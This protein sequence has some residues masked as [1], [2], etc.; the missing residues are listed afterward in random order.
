MKCR[1]RVIQRIISAGILLG[2]SLADSRAVQ[3]E[4]LQ[5]QRFE[6]PATSLAGFCSSNA[7]AARLRNAQANGLKFLDRPS[8]GSGLARCGGDEFV[9]ISDRGPNGIG[10]ANGQERR[11]FPLPEFS[12]F[13]VRFELVDGAI[14]IRQPLFLTDARGRRL[15]GLSN[16]AG[17]ERLYESAAATAPL[18]FDPNGVDPEA[19]RV[20]PDGKFL[21]AEEY[22]PSVLLVAPNG[23]VLVRYTPQTKMLAGAAYPVKPILP[24]VLA[25]RRD[26]RGFEAL[27]LS[28]DGRTAFA[29]LQSPAG[30]LTD[31]Q[32]QK[33][34]VARTI[35]LDLSDPFNARVTGHFLMPLSW[36]T[37]Y[38]PEQKQANVKLN[39]AEWLAP[40]KLL[41]LETGK[42]AA[43]LI[44]ADF[45]QATNLLG[46]EDENT[47]A[48]EAVGEDLPQLPVKPATTEV[49]LALANRNG[50]SQ[51]LEGLAILSADEIALANDNDF[52]LGD[53]ETGER[54]SVWRL[55]LPRPLP[56][57]G[58]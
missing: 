54:S 53:N 28:P 50:L 45:S 29:I 1:P 46:R 17:E 31:E 2:I 23:E 16:E 32:S 3:A 18:P 33:S 30:K 51:K 15:T 58:R 55:R 26:N 13:V 19:I 8:L 56:L 12:P 41:V 7:T 35:R 47:L 27:A 38:G 4:A 49:W 57:S 14:R 9:G 36:A 43:R 37:N 39:D 25:R 10:F 40:D 42:D 21:L 44:V 5:L 52:G 11:T 48:F 20:L 24:S 34:R 6:L 22:G